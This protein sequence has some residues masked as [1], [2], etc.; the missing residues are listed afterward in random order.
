MAS[1]GPGKYKSQPQEV[2]GGEINRIDGVDNEGHTGFT[3]LSEFRRAHGHS[4]KDNDGTDG[5]G[6]QY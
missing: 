3:S 1:E 2:R 4:D 6:Y 5:G